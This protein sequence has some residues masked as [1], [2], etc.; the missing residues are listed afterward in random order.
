[1]RIS[2]SIV[3]L[4]CLHTVIPAQE[5]VITSSFPPL[6]I[7][8]RDTLNNQ[9]LDIADLC[10]GFDDEGL[11]INMVI[12]DYAITRV[13]IPHPAREAMNKFWSLNLN[14]DN[15]LTYGPNGQVISS[16]STPR[17]TAISRSDY[18]YNGD[19]VLVVSNSPLY[20]SLE[21]QI[22]VVGLSLDD[23]RV[24]S[25]G[26]TTLFS[27]KRDRS[28]TRILEYSWPVRCWSL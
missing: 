9:L 3:L 15:V 27:F 4:A 23:K 28:M 2:I 8:V 24:A 25:F 18:I 11:P 19:T 17:L 22:G 20:G 7:Q 1:M 5:T 14:Y 16:S 26:D 21:R 12:P 10:D 6:G 13:F